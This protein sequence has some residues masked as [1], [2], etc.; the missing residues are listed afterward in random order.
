MDATFLSRLQFG[1]TIGF[2]YIFP[3]LTIGLAWLIVVMMTR[4]HRRQD[5]VARAAARFWVRIFALTFAMGVA[6][7]ITMD[8][9][10]G[11]NWAA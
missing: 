4:A 8:F 1:L 2:H 9:Q 10:F 7:G 5:P 3:T 6:T 11:T